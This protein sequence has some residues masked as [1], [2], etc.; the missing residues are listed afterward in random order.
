MLPNKL[1]KKTNRGL[2][3]KN[4]SKILL[5]RPI[6]TAIMAISMSTETGEEM[7]GCSRQAK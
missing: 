4:K 3:R 5:L 7:V 6:E 2:K 1:M